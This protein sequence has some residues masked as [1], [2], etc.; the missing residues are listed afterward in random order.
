MAVLFDAVVLRILILPSV[1]T[2]LGER[3]WW[4]R[5]PARAAAG[6]S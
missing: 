4:P 1:L 5:H 6:A 3:S 2:L